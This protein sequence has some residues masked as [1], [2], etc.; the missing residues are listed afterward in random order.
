[1]GLDGS[2]VYLV[3]VVGLLAI[4]ILVYIS[5]PD[6]IPLGQVVTSN[7]NTIPGREKAQSESLRPHNILN[8]ST[9]NITIIY[10]G[11]SYE[12]LKKYCDRWGYMLSKYL[13]SGIHGTRTFFLNENITDINYGIP[14]TNIIGLGGNTKYILFENTSSYIC[15]SKEFLELDKINRDKNDRI[16]PIDIANILE[17]GY[18]HYNNNGVIV[19]GE[20][21]HNIFSN[22]SLPFEPP[23]IIPNM[24]SRSF[25]KITPSYSK[26]P[27]V[28]YQTFKSHAIPEC[29]DQGIKLWVENNDM[30]EYHY[31]DDYDQREYIKEHFD[32]NVLEA[33][34]SLVPGAYRSDLWRAC[35]I[36]REGGIYIDVKLFP[37]ISIDSII[38]SD[39]DFLFVNDVVDGRI[40]NAF[41]AAS[42][43][44]PC[45]LKIIDVMTQR[46]SSR[47]YGNSPVYPTGPLAWFHAIS[48][49]Y[50][51]YGLH[52]TGKFNVMDDIIQVYQHSSINSNN[53]QNNHIIDTS[54][55]HV[56][57]VRHKLTNLSGDFLYKITGLPH[58]NFLW[59][60]KLV[61]RG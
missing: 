37:V 7:D 61:Y 38:D 1:M 58:Y 50:N 53:Y 19:S 6:Y 55:N 56:I 57:N 45:I 14:L 20:Y 10:N 40:S 11:D 16:H 2:L 44:H 9:G 12:R 21:L 26:I 23:S 34:D 43:K 17:H 46:I 25:S 5:S 48:S 39:T 47:E 51:F 29:L 13:H 42:P 32:K 59:L 15:R 24:V 22:T 4:L 35:V 60:K 49:Y 28:I 3:A 54:S 27:K 36:Y 41:F 30:H 33:Y 18:P 31:F 8:E 52:P